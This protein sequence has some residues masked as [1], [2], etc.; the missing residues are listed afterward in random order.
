[1]DGLRPRESQVA[2]LLQLASQG[3]DQILDG[4]I[5]PSG[6]PWGAGAIVPIHSAE[7]LALGMADPMMNS[8]LTDIEIVSDRVRRA[9]AS[10]GGHDGSSSSGFPFTLLMAAS[11][12]GRGFSVQITPD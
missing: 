4:G 11:Q 12:E 10:D 7:S 9:T 5:G 8:G 1:V 6:F 3:Q 2:D